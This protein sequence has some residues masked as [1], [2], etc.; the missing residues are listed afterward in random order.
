MI[1][2][3]NHINILVP[4]KKYP[5]YGGEPV[6]RTG[7]SPYILRILVSGYF[8]PGTSSN[9][10]VQAMGVI[11]ILALADKRAQ[12]TRGLSLWIIGSWGLFR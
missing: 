12:P 10:A 9:V 4:G 3:H 2:I 6:I 7:F 11:P 8:L 1:S 5:G